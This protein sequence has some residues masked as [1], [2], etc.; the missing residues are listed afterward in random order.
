MANVNE[1]YGKTRGWEGW[2]IQYKG[3]KGGKVVHPECASTVSAEIKGCSI[4]G[5][6]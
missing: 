3:Y 5:Y 4:P 1:K 6:N 2:E